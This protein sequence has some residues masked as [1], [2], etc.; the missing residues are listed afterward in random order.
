MKNI[1]LYDPTLRDGNHA[2]SHS[3]SLNDIKNYCKIIDNCE[4][5]CV[6]VGHGN[7][8]GASS[9]QLGLASHSDEDML[10]TA[11]EMLKNTRLGAH[12]I[13]GFAKLD[14]LRMAIDQGV[15]IL[16]IACHCTEANTTSR[17]IELVKNSGKLAQGVLMMTHLTSPQNLLE[18]A[19]LQVSYGSDA[20]IIMDSAGAYTENDVYER[21]SLLK[22]NINIPI[23]FH[24]HN[25]LGL[26]IAN[27]ITAANAGASIIDGTIKGIGA[28]AGNTAL[29]VLC[30]VMMKLGLLN[31][32]KALN[33]ISISEKLVA[34]FNSY[35]SDIKPVNI[36]SGLY[37]VFSGFEKPVLKFSKEYG[38]SPYDIFKI[39]GDRKVVAGQ[40]D[41]II[42]I[43]A[44]LA[45]QS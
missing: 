35:R 36:I 7:G 41:I 18:Q 6:E 42:E 22:E 34:T 10:S 15:D 13:P 14:D 40:E 39:L 20:I 33:T 24:G 11:R 21:I 31:E 29:E 5:Y 38:V 28:G 43:A 23:G 2:L 17:Y 32:H 30:A 16:R 19:K 27:S 45:K 25:N 1:Q 37:G 3:I 8:L 12:A 26:A 44:E 9:L 4:L